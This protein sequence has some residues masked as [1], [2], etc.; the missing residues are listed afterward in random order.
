MK[1]A[2]LVLGIIILI[3]IG[4]YFMFSPDKEQEEM[5]GLITTE[6]VAVTG[7]VSGIN[8]ERMAVDGPGLITIT[9]DETGTEYTIA[10]PSGSLCDAYPN[11]VDI[12]RITIG[13]RLS[14]RGSQ[15]HLRNE[16]GD[17]IPCESEEHY[18]RTETAP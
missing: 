3:I 9:E 11:M 13:D 18:L 15:R 16:K 17:I 2:L 7:T 6:E 8:L 14:V 1:N 5:P 12:T 10:I 4:G